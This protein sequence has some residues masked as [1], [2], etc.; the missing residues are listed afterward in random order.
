MVG[1]AV[2]LSAEPASPLPREIRVV[3]YNI[4]HGEGSD[5]KVDLPR[6]ANVLKAATPDVVAL[7]EIDQGTRRT[8]GVDTPAELAKLLSMKP[9]FARNIDFEGGGYGTLVLT[10]LPIKGVELHRLP[11][12]YEGE[13]RGVQLVEL[14]AGDDSLILF[15]THLDYRPDD[16]ERLDSVRTIGSLAG[17]YPDKPMILAGDL[18]AEPESRVM[19]TLDRDW[20]RT[21]AKGLRTYPADKP[22][23]EI[24][25][26]LVKPA[27]R[28]QVVETRVLDE[29]IASDH[30]PLLTVLRRVP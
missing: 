21:N 18:N 20:T 15:C 7:Q 11:S 3:T 12:H 24:D 2:V 4:H 29:S 5:G 23:K 19:Q 13:Q 9:V 22:A 10:R 8:G 6:I 16:A 14:G 26:I 30:R 28:W 1:H 27:A 25:Y 17:A